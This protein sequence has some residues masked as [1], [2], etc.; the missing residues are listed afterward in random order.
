VLDK[1]RLTNTQS[2]ERDNQV[3]EFIK[4]IPC[5]SDTIQ[6]MFYTSQRMANKHLEHLYKYSHIKRY[7]KFAHEKYFYYTGKLKSQ[8]EHLDI[9]AKT[10]FWLQQNGYEI[11]NCKLQQIQQGIKPDLV[12]ELKRNNK[13]TTVAIEIERSYGNLKQ[14]IKKYENTDFKSVLL[15]S[16]LPTGNIENEYIQNLNNINF[17]ELE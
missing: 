1:K 8:R 10:Y 3:V 13:I 4:L 11:L 16:N 15:I 14:T 9:A 5:Y 2:K 7:R 17:K 12:V 6:K